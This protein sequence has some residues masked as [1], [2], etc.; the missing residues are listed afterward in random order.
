[1]ERVTLMNQQSRILR[2]VAAETWLF[3]DTGYITL[4]ILRFRSSRISNLAHF[5]GF[6]NK[7]CNTLALE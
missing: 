4:E 6:D 1:M 5:D 3:S 7:I 2:K